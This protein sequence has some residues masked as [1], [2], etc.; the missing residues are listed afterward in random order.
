MNTRHTFIRVAALVLALF[1]N[2]GGTFS[3]NL[4]SNPEHIAWDPLNQRYL[5][6]N[7]GN[8]TVVSIDQAG[9]QQTLLRGL[10][11]CMGIHIQ[12]TVLMVSF[13]KKI[14]FFDLNTLRQFRE[15]TLNASTWLDGMITDNQRNAYAVESGGKIF[16]INLDT[17]E[18]TTIVSSGIPQYAQDLAFDPVNNRLIV[19]AWEINSPIKAVNLSNNSVTTIKTTQLGNFD[20]VVR[21]SLGNLYVS[22]HRDGGKVYRFDRSFEQAPSVVATGLLTPAGLC[23]NEQDN[24]LAVP[25]FDGNSVSYIRGVYTGIELNDPP[26]AFHYR[27][28]GNELLIESPEPCRSVVFTSLD[29]RVVRF[30]RPESSPWRID[31]NPFRCSY[32]NQILVFTILTDHQR[33]SGKIFLND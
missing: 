18:A 10:T 5:V 2:P 29:G 6:T 4:L 1:L 26:A 14:R 16:K 8:G 25:N 19:V 27:M 12:D 17:F 23:L 13:G 24:I 33:Y 32:A 22:C 11:Q 15:V 3:Q 21:D 28:Y 7:Y 30:V 9:V 20:G 31:M